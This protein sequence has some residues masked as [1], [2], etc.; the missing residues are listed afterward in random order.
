MLLAIRGLCLIYRPDQTKTQTNQIRQYAVLFVALRSRS[1]AIALWCGM[2]SGVIKLFKFMHC[3]LTVVQRS[4]IP[5]NQTTACKQTRAFNFIISAYQLEY[6]ELCC[7]RKKD[8][9]CLF[10]KSSKT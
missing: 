5:S 1:V 3:L 10:T 8:M 7:K 9:I 2:K 4:E 6:I